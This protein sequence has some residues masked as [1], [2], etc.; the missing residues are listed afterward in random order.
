VREG[1]ARARERTSTARDAPPDGNLPP[2]ASQ[3]DI[4]GP[5]AA[6]ASRPQGVERGQ[7]EGTHRLDEPPVLKECGL[8]LD[9]ITGHPCLDLISESL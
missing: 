7:N 8:I 3:D 9:V 2:G 1:R 6:R 5:R 4:A